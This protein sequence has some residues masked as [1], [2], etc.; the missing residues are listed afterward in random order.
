MPSKQKPTWRPGSQ[1]VY[2]AWDKGDEFFKIGMTSKDLE[3]YRKR[4]CYENYGRRGYD[5]IEIGCSW[6]FEDFWAAWYVEQ[7]TIEL[8]ERFGF[9]RTRDKDW[10]AI[11]K[12]TM[13]VVVELID[14]LAWDIRKWEQ[15]NFT[16]DLTFRPGLHSAWGKALLRAGLA[17][18]SRDFAKHV[19][20][21]SLNI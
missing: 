18:Y 1:A 7:T 3:R 6:L 13:S 5:K 12:A 11:D 2:V 4:L 9:P 19:L 16:P 17:T 20:S 21:A 10:F 8:I 15:K 14:D